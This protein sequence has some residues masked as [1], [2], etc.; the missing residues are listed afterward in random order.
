LQGRT[1]GSGG[2]QATP[3]YAAAD[4]D[5][6]TEMGFDRDRAVQALCTS[7]GSVERAAEWLL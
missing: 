5:M 2:V 4:V 1:P 6:L 3:D 7:S